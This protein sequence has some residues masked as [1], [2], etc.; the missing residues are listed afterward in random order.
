M[1]LRA[2][3]IMSSVPTSCIQVESTVIGAPVAS[4]WAKF[5]ELKLEA[6]AP[7]YVTKTETTGEG[8]GS[9]VT[10][11]YKDETVWEL[12]ITEISVRCCHRENENTKTCD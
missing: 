6:V 5:R 2:S 4:V 1:S 3:Q 7:T 8:V 10:V 12:R 9:V 11:T